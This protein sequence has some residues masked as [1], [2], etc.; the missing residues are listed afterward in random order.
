MKGTVKWFSP[1]KGYGFIT[2]DDTEATQG[3]DVFAH[4]TAIEGEGY[5]N[6]TEGE[7][8]SFDLV[9]VG[10]GPQARNVKRLHGD[11]VASDLI[12]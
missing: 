3:Q 6:L 9:D 1:T 8:V 12:R 5:R 11:V 4:H 2:P 7:R 10:K